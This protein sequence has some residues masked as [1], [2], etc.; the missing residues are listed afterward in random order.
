MS[1]ELAEAVENLFR[2]QKIWIVVY[3]DRL[4]LKAV[5]VEA[6]DEKAAAQ[7]ATDNLDRNIKIKSV[8]LDQN[9]PRG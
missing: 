2:R 3:E 8:T 7:V 5:W 4:L 1:D 9:P 6:A